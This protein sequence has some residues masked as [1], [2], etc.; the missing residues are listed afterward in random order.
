MRIILLADLCTLKMVAMKNLEFPK[1]SGLVKS[2]GKTQSIMLEL[3]SFKIF[4]RKVCAKIQINEEEYLKIYP[5]AQNDI[6]SGKVK[7]AT[8]HFIKFG[9]YQQ[10]QAQVILKK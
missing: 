2:D 4:F 9:F 10:R 6:D 7:N 5:D 8:E 3:H 1:V